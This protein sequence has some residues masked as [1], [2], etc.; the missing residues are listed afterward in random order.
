MVS[1][2]GV[3]PTKNEENTL[4]LLPHGSAALTSQRGSM[5]DTASMSP[6]LNA[7]SRRAFASSGPSCPTVTLPRSRN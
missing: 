3:I 4:Q 5:T 1:I 6:I 7:V 2:P